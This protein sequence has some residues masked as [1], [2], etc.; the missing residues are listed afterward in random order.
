MEG[1]IKGLIDVALGHNNRDD[2][3]PRDERSRSTWAEVSTTLPSFAFHLF[4]VELRSV[5]GAKMRRWCPGSRIT[6]RTEVI[7]LM[8][9][10][11]TRGIDRFGSDSL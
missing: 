10:L 5:T 9:I 7:E 6:T 3:E 2:E 1:L 4:T 11:R 8:A